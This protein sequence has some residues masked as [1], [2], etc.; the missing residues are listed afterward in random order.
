MTALIQDTKRDQLGGPDTPVPPALGF[1]IEANTQVFA[2]GLCALNAAGNVVRP[3]TAGALQCPGVANA[4]VNNLTTNVPFGAA[5]AQ[6]VNIRVGAFPF[7]TDGTFSAGAVF[8]NAYAIDDNTLSAD[9]GGGTRPY[10][11]FTIQNPLLG[12][13]PTP[14]LVYAMIGFPNPY[15]SASDGGSLAYKARNVISALSGT[16][17]GSGTGTL[18]AS[19]NAAFGV[20]NGVTNSVGDV[21]FLLAGTTHITA[22]SD[23]GPYILTNAGSASTKWVLSRPSWWFTG[24]EMAIG[25]GVKV[26]GEDTLFGGST[27]NSFAAQG[28]VIDTTDPAFYPDKVTQQVTLVAGVKAITNVPLRS[29]TKSDVLVG[30]AGSGTPDASTVSFGVGAITP[31][32]LGTAT[33]TA[34]AYEAA[35]VTNTS[36]VSVVNVTIFN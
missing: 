19:A 7:A 13:S 25:Q 4:G 22:A 3:Q 6:Q 12:A 18:T 31:G 10:A 36:D 2:G 35:M 14:T 1:N 24:A 17:A 30:Y 32:A 33:V 9:D 15:A 20:Q 16:Y 27:M 34:K 11:G 29:A 28:S 26:G 23:A 21:V 5:G 8:Q